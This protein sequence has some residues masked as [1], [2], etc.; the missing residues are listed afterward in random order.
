[1]EEI[2][3]KQIAKN[4]LILVEKNTNKKVI[5]CYIN[6]VLNPTDAK[7]LGKNYKLIQSATDIINE[8]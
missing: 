8:K 6:W 2:D 4:I 3:Y 7:Y 5:E 1:M